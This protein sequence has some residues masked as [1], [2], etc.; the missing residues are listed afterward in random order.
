MKDAEATRRRK[1]IRLRGYDYSLPGAYFVT[2]VTQGRIPRFGEVLD[3][4]MLL[5][6]TGLW[7]ADGWEWLA[8]QYP[9]VALDEYVVMPNHLHGVIVI[10]DQPRRG[11]SRTAPT[12]RKPLGRLIGAFKTVTTKRINLAE[13]T[14]GQMVWQRNY[15]ERVI[16]SADEMDRIRQYIV[17]N[18]LSWETDREN[19]R[20]ERLM[21]A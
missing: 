4:E 2:I 20:G 17:E 11:G 10:A 3:G 5:S 18:P 14:P 9:Y 7:I 13:G 12:T 16:R 19:P 8:R 1:S 21:L 6:P 15:Y